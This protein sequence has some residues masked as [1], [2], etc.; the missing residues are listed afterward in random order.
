MFDAT[1]SGF[2]GVH[3][4]SGRRP[5][6]GNG[7]W[8]GRQRR[9]TFSRHEL[10]STLVDVGYLTVLTALG[11]SQ[12]LLC[13]RGLR[14]GLALFRCQSEQG[15]L[16]DFLRFAQSLGEQSGP[17]RRSSLPASSQ[18]LMQMR[19]DCRQHL[20]QRGCIRGESHRV[21]FLAMQKSRNSVHRSAL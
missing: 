5:G 1:A 7:L 3:R 14:S 19:P 15:C 21:L 6:C 17:L 8:L 9:G 11:S 2:A 12:T 10:N 16:R 18:A 4:Y 13:D 20:W